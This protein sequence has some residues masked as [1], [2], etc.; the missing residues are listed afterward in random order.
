MSRFLNHCN[1]K[2]LIYV[3]L[4]PRVGVAHDASVGGQRGGGGDDLSVCA[5]S[6]GVDGNF[7]T[8]STKQYNKNSITFIDAF[9]LKSV[10]NQPFPNRQ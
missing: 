2:R 5:A 10:S 7:D 3:K 4:N 6:G 9:I 1:H 8:N